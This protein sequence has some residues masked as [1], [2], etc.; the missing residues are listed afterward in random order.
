MKARLPFV[1]E[2][3]MSLAVLVSIAGC[4]SGTFSEQFPQPSAVS[5]TQPVDDGPYTI[6][7]HLGRDGDRN[8]VHVYINGFGAIDGDLNE[9]YEGVSYGTYG[10]HDVRVEC[11]A[12]RLN[13]H[14]FRVVCDV[15]VD[16]V[17]ESSFGF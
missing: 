3:V 6:Y 9:E 11:R 2:L 1:L 4:S 17:K 13:L 7:G 14:D 12:R 16:E 15:F 10:S 5:S 8:R